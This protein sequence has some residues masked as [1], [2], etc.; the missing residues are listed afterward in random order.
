MAN[1]TDA[2][3]RG[4]GVLGVRNSRAITKVL[5]KGVEDVSTK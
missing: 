4:D 3:W 2:Y 1:H 5:Y